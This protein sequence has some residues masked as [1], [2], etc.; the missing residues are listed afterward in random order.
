M[1]DF[2]RT[3]L[4]LC[5]ESGL[6]PQESVLNQFH[7][8]RAA[9]DSARLDLTMQ[10]LSVDT[11]AV[12][13]RVL[14][15]DVLF[16]EVVLSDCM[17]SEEGVKLLLYGLCSNTTV[18]VLDLKG[19]NMR[20]VGSEA[21]G[22]LLRQNK[23]IRR[24]T[25]EW[26]ALG[27][28][29][30]A[31]SI[32]CEGLGSNEALKQLD[33]RNNQINHQ[34]AGELAMALKR[35][36]TLQE[37]DLR[38]NNIG[39]LGGSALLESLQQNRTLL[40]LEMAGNNVPS[41]TLKAVEQS[42]D[43]NSDR[44]ST[45]KE[46]RSKTQVLRKEI[47][48]LREEK[49]KQFLNMMETIDKQRDL[50][51]SSRLQ[52]TEAALALSEQKSHDLGELLSRVKLEKSELKER[53]SR[54]M[55]KGQKEAV[56]REGK[57]IRELQIS[58]EKNLHL[59]SK[60]DELEWRCNAQRDHVFDLKQELTNSTAELK[61]QLAHA[62]AYLERLISASPQTYSNWGLKHRV[63]VNVD[64]LNRHREESE[65]SLQDRV[66]KL[67]EIRIQLE[68]Q[69][70][71][72]HMEEKLR[73]LTQSRDESQ[74]HCTQQKQTVS[75]LQAKNNHLALEM[76]G[77]KRR[78]EEL[79]QEL[80][81]KEQEKVAE[82]NKVRVELQEQIGHLQAERATQG[83]LK[84]KI[85]VLEREMKVQTSNHREALLDKESETVSLLEKLRL[86]DSEIMRMRED[87]AQRASFLQKAILTYVQGSPLGS[88]SPKK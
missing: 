7:D 16:T 32:F 34:G 18:K 44:K 27:M 38:W 21:L 17:L 55:N 78:I 15:N 58:T 46:S 43:H 53:Q 60:V 39:L 11:C 47:W 25:L 80:G 66:Q 59:K 3:Y 87:E 1:E 61:L 49:G 19:N 65:R 75:E 37:L 22:K 36:T 48:S 30:E 72:S 4:R 63:P 50:G 54:E 69:Q 24:L 81:G 20:A 26:N 14:S 57:L 79:Q 28:W 51:R 56:I 35:N 10:S 40:Q 6:E 42:I 85:A 88:Y 33:L 23:S 13:G 8:V 73:L 86:K 64:Q 74:I 83:G 52:M 41:D 5:K 12:L 2:R 68:E 9:G 82:V 71:V 76:E 62:E 84:E 31:F 77:L 29:G 45:L 67:E 70:R